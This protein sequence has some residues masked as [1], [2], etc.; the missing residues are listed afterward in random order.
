[1]AE[2]EQ[3]TALS[4]VATDYAVVCS[5]KGVVEAVC[6]RR[7]LVWSGPMSTG[8]SCW[9]L[10]NWAVKQNVLPAP[11][12]LVTQIFPPIICTSRNEMLNPSPVPPCLRVVEPS[13]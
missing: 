4:R 10:W 12:R 8:G 2:S 13:A 9:T 6:D 7:P 5:G 3:G 1:M 11:G